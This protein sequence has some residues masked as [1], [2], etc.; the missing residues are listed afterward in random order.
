LVSARSDHAKVAVL[1]FIIVTSAELEK[2][3]RNGEGIGKIHYLA[4]GVCAIEIS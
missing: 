1:G 3:G 4:I 2:A